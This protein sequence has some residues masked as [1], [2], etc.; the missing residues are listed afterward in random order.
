MTSRAPR[1]PSLR[2]ACALGLVHAAA[3][4]YWAAGG[5]WLVETVGQWAV[6]WRQESPASAAVVLTLV[7]AVK[8][9]GALVPLAVEAGHLPGRRWW[10]AASWAGAAVLVLYGTANT[11]GA[12]VVLAGLLDPSGPQDDAALW[13]HAV[14]W[15]PLFACWGVTLALGLRATR[16]ATP[17]GPPG[18]ASPRPASRAARAR[19]R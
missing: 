10:R 19:P 12:W 9:A 7:A 13:G 5:S 15:D 11:V 14:L 3:S 1:H 2:V 16:H 8:A 18:V 17:E 6:D 4:A